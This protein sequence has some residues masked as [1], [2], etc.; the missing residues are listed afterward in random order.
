MLLDLTIVIPVR[1]EERNLPGCLAAIG[2]NFVQKIII[3]DSG[4]NDKTR[5]I[6]SSFGAEVI[7]FKWNGQFPKKRN[8]FLQNHLPS[9][10]WILFLDADE[11]LTQNF[12]IELTEKL[13][14][15]DIIGYWL[16]YSIYFMGKELKGGY[17]LKKLALF[18][19]GAGE[20][21]RIDE[22]N[23]SKLDMEIHEHPILTGKVGQ[24]KSKIDHQD[25]RGMSH[26]INKH[27]EYSDWEAERF[28]NAINSNSIT[29]EWTIKQR[30]KY[31]LVN[32]ILVGPIF[33][34]GS[35]FFYGGFRDGTR[36]LA[37]AFLK[38]SYFNQ[39]YCKIQELKNNQNNY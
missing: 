32:S 14:N 27:N 4:S 13:S 17:P 7:N 2:K 1:N 16:N 23:W 21:E 31:K 28:L 10:K 34:F 3:I 18:C 6:A 12:K 36:G 39:V 9:T 26:Y 20:Y 22:K 8:W 29:E 25:Y 19:T 38:L 30:L 5:D 24:V 33:F 11:Y 37:F 35:F 15:N